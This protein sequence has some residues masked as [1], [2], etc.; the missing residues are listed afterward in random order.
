MQIKSSIATLA[1]LGALSLPAAVSAQS[2]DRVEAA[3]APRLTYVDQRQPY[4][5]VRR[6]A[7]DE[8]YREGIRHGEQD[9]RRG[10]RFWYEDERTYQRGDKGYHRGYGDRGRYQ[11]AFRSGYAAGYSDGYGRFG[12][13]VRRDNRGA[14]GGPRY[15]TGYPGGGYGRPG[16]GYVNPAVEHGLREGYEKGV[17]DA[18][19]NRSFDARRHKWYREGDRHYEGR[20]G[21]RDF[22]KDQYRRAF[23]EG[24]DRGYREGRFRY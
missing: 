15:G 2:A 23:Q 6:A 24:Y 16:Y 14:Y 12:R 8:G 18:R 10:D 17:E 5:D 19:K 22:Y 1:A 7:Y 13:G 21:S 4:N 3:G 9:G 20:Y 11:V